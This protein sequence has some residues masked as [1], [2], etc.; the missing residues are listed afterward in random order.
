MVKR[1]RTGNNAR[2]AKREKD[3]DPD[4]IFIDSSNLPNF[5]THQFEGRIEKSISQRTLV[6]LGI[7]F[8]L[9][10][11]IFISKVWSLQIKQGDYYF[12]KSENNRLRNSLIFAKRGV[13]YDRVGTELAWNTENLAEEN[14]YDLRKYIPLD[15]FAH[16]LGYL[17]YPSKDKYGFYYTDVFD[18]KDGVEKAFN[19]ALSGENGKRIVEVDAL[20]V[21]QSENIIE[22]PNDGENLKLS[23][24][25][26]V[27]SEMYQ[28]IKELAD[29]VG[30]A[31]GAGIIM[32]VTSGEILALTSYPE[33]NSQILT[34]GQD[35]TKIN[36]YLTNKNNP[37][38][39]RIVDGL[40]TPGSTVKPY[41]AYAALGENVIDQ[42]QNILSTGALILPNPYDSTR[43]TIF[44]DWKAHGYVDMRKALAVSSDVYFYEVGGGFEDQKGLGILTIDK[45][46]KLFGFGTAVPVSTSLFDGPTGVIP[47]PEWK[48]AN[49]EGE[50]WR[51]GNTYHTSIGQYGFQVSPLQLVRA[52][53][54]LANG[55]KLLT[56]KILLDSTNQED[57]LNINLNPAYLKVVREGMRDGVTKD[58]GVARALNSGD[59]TVAAKTGTAEL[60]VYKQFVNSWVSGFFPYENPRYAFVVIMEKGPVANTTGAVFVMR[61]VM[62][63]IAQNKPEYLK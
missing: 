33:Y 59:Y 54:A 52:V 38:L 25:A 60:G 29:R 46:M 49:F 61:Q 34:D 53:G 3:I 13:I 57:S 14:S 21:M 12:T 7:A 28:A 58:Y 47:T 2:Y 62:D 43:P 5:D 26:G 40:Y 35:K 11:L 32:D 31:G 56:P 36:K 9:I 48:L 30:F 20:G 10:F 24:D 23:I 27:Q 8:L 55:G 19:T 17:K 63:W 51:V 44:K 39:N 15:G 42:Y 37:F 50:E 4:E 45:Y 16:L 18:G 6:V 22:N 1:G 41:I